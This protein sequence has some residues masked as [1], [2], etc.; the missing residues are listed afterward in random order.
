MHKSKNRRTP[1][2]GRRG[3]PRTRGPRP[4]R[5]P[6]PAPRKNFE[7]RG[8]SIEP[9]L[10]NHTHSAASHL[11]YPGGGSRGYATKQQGRRAITNREIQEA[12]K[13]GD[14]HV[15]ENGRIQHRHPMYS[16]GGHQAHRLVV[17]TEADGTLVVT[18]FD[19]DNDL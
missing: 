4:A 10:H 3:G 2:R 14:K 1:R 15:Q 12:L 5:P 19:R 8:H 6:R 17:I 16:A 7:R 13:H 11:A 9:H 18:Q